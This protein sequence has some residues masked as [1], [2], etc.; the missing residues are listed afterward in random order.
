MWVT[1]KKHT[2]TSSPYAKEEGEGKPDLKVKWTKG[3][4]RTKA[5]VK[6]QGKWRVHQIRKKSE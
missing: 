4:Q 1:N 3:A 5:A 2:S 6:V